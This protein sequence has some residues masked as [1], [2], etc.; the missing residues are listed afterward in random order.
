MSWSERAIR[1]P[2]A[3]AMVFVALTVLGAMSYTRL[4]VDLFPEL[5]FPSISVVTT[6]PGVSP[7]EI[8]TLITR[9][10]EAA[11]ARVE[12]IDRIESF[13][14]EG[15]SRVALRFTWGMG[16]DEAMNEVRAA[17]E[18]VRSTLPDEANAP[19]VYRFNLTNLP[20]ASMAIESD[21]EEVRLRRFADDIIRPYLE[22]ISGIAS[23]DVRGARDREI[24][25]ELD[26]ERLAALELSPS[27]VTRAVSSGTATV[28]AG[29]VEVADEN[30]LLRALAEYESTEAIG[31]ALVVERDGVAVRVRD[32]AE[33]VD[34]AEEA[35]NLVRINGVEG[36]RAS[37]QKS[38]DAN[39]V[40]V[41]DRLRAAVEAFNR[42]YE[43]VAQ[44]RLL[45]DSSVYIR[46]SI[47]GV[48]TAILAGAGLAL[49]VLLFFLRDVRA[50]L[51]IAVSIPI[52]IVGTFLLMKQLDLTLNLITFGGLALGLGMLVDGAIV[53]LENIYRRQERGERPMTAAI[54]GSREV[55]GAITAGTMTTLVVFLPVI[56]LG[57]FAAVFFQQM[58]LVVSAALLCS[59]IVALTLVPVLASVLLRQRATDEGGQKG[60]LGRL[61]DA[62]D[63]IYARLVAGLMNKAF[64]VVLVGLALLGGAGYLSQEIGSELLPEADESEVAVYIRYPAGTRMEVTQAAVERVEAVI[65]R[66]VPEAREV[67]AALGSPGFWSSSGEEFAYVDLFLVPVEERT[68]SSAEIADALRPAL[69]AATPGSRT[70]VRAGGGLWVFSFLRGGPDRLRVEIRGHD[71]DIADRL[72]AQVVERVVEVEGVTDARA[73]RQPGGREVQLSVDRDRAADAGL[74][75]RAVAE[76]IGTLVQGSQAARYRESGDEFAVRVRLARED[77]QSTEGVL[78]TPVALPDGRSVPLRSL[79]RVSDGT[80]PLDID[81]YN[82][83]RIVTVGGGL[84]EGADLGEVNSA[85]RAALREIDVPYGYSV[86][87]AGESAEQNSAF[88]SLGLGIVLA[89][90]LVFMVMAGQFESFVHPFV[91][92]LSVPFAGIGVVAVL[93][94][95]GTTLNLNSLMGCIVLVGVVVNNAIVLVDS[96]NQLRRSEGVALREAVV[97]ASRRRLRPILMTTATTVLALLPVAIGGGTGGENQVPLAR[98]VVGGLLA[99][100]LVTLA[101]VPVLYYRVERLR[102]RWFG[103]ASAVDGEG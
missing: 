21:L 96:I 62:L 73:S 20:V 99:S 75:T 57:G 74:T 39:T 16:L 34:D 49:L 97:E 35:T 98:V 95:T 83:E 88:T 102:A 101:L 86:I 27:D 24:R 56:F 29:R 1:R 44:L 87:V 19:V 36:V 58:A 2:I 13:S 61:L 41:S 59:L 52:S 72:A 70:G 79:V 76:L 8:E 85:V 90:M 69:T 11:V 43:G 10:I 80:T 91:I 51:V 7:E 22:R 15:R 26:A 5:D 4:Q 50:T 40:E 67:M 64:V 65:A 18:R 17:V 103:G 78:N 94:G 60:P 25:V 53:I 45:E 32:V 48:R 9:P 31:D 28:A 89:L 23:V 12:G 3:T 42:D 38:P 47:D 54:E 71:L 100:T 82:Q 30:V 6:Y 93:V 55:A 81:R 37:V 14:A 84:E 63:R 46:R 77:L 66:E 68:R 92:L 33:V